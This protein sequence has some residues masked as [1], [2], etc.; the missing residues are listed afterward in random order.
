MQVRRLV[1]GCLI[2]V[3]TILAMMV[4]VAVRRHVGGMVEGSYGLERPTGRM[5]F[6]LALTPIRLLTTGHS[7]PIASSWVFLSRD[8]FLQL[9]QPARHFEIFR[10]VCNAEIGLVYSLLLSLPSFLS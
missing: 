9:P 2:A 5:P 8:Q 10:L 6:R 3:A 7:S 4:F 1:K